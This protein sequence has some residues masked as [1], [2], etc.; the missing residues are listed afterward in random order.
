MNYNQLDQMIQYVEKNLTE[1]V[2]YLKLARIVGLPP[3]ILQ[4]IFH[5]MTE[6]T[7][8]EYIR[9]RRLSKAYEALSKDEKT[10]TELAFL[11]CYSSSSS[12]SR[13]FKKAFGISPK[14]V[15]KSKEIISFPKIVFKENLI[16]GNSFSY[17]ILNLEEV[18]LYGKSC[19]IDD[20]NYVSQIYQLYDFLEKEELLQQFKKAIW[21][22]ITIVA[23]DKTYYFVGSR[24]KYPNL[25][26]YQIPKSKYILVDV[27][28]GKQKDI[29]RAEI[30]MFQ[31]YL[32]STDYQYQEKS[33]LYEL[34]IYNRENC[35]VALPIY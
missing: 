21:Y 4:R 6:M 16:S 30:K 34:E 25:E 20:E 5:F 23:K 31:S 27:I 28:S 1:P 26:K 13:A 32:P 15:K 33:N 10:V 18:T 35:S 9:K 11:Y 17:Q 29:V 22:G 19:V 7:I 8:A 24:K 3:Y 2:D 14:E 12:F